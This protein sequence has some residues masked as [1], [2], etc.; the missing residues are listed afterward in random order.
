MSG[1]VLVDVDGLDVSFPADG[2]RRSVVRDLSLQV[3]AGRTVALVGESGSGKSV[4]ARALVGLAG[5]GGQVRARRLDVLGRDG[6][7]L[8]PRQWR[9]V[10]GKEVGFV[11]QDALSSLDPLRT[12]GQEITE[13][14]TAHGVGSRAERRARV[15]EVLTEVGVPEPAVRAAQRSG[16]LSGGL[17]QRALIAQALAL[18]P[19]VLVADEPTTA[20]DATVQA[21]VLDVLRGLVA[22][23][24]GLVLISHDLAVVSS[25]ADD[26]LV[27][28]D[29]EVVEQGTV[30]QVL[31]APRHPYTRT[32]LDAVP[33]AHARGTRLSAAPRAGVPVHEPRV[34]VLD[35][36]APVLRAT[37]LRKVYRGPDGVDRVVVDGVSFTLHAGTTL[38]VVGESGSGK[39]TTARIAL[40]LTAPD[41]GEVLLGGRAWSA[42]PERGRRP[43]RG[44][45]QVV[46]QDPLGSFDPRHTVRRV[47]ED[48]LA[49]GG[50]P[51]GRGREA[52]LA[53][54]ADQ[55]GLPRT[56]LDRR[57]LTL[58]GGQ[59]QRV[60]VARALAPD[61]AVLVL[62]EPVSALDV[63]IQAQVLDLLADLQADRGL[64][65]LFISHDLGV[66]HHVSDEVL[67]MSEGRVV[68]HGPAE[69][70]LLTPEHPYTRTLV[71]SVPRLAPHSAP[72][73]ARPL[74]PD[75]ATPVAVH[76]PA[77]S[78]S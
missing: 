46:H 74:A 32:L 9:E 49:A 58:S 65:Y 62:D 13:A 5:P 12:V 34:S 33:V 41:A 55:V 75:L 6:L 61:P 25:V 1:E 11:L 16:E 72:A 22:R 7:T 15:L 2:G 50:L 48:A 27:L 28:R 20:L 24:H 10:R 53:E 39:S 19:R 76:H 45:I 63:S 38:G 56:V 42:L 54:L 44:E 77:R 4:T 35:P 14:L 73:T 8:G 43:L 29:G 71:A 57:P 70:V 31:T 51:R 52:R 30:E 66:V 78:S 37:G 3:R 60:A 23:G 18:D 67:V 17:R 26:V 59:R 64:A 68:E 40:G 21:Q 47:L 36:G 69:R